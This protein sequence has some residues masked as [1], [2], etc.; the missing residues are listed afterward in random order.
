M[1]SAIRPAKH[2]HTPTNWNIE[3]TTSSTSYNITS[4]RHSNAANSFNAFRLPETPVVRKAVRPLPPSPLPHQPAAQ[5]SPK[6]ISFH[7]LP[8]SP[9]R[10][11][12]YIPTQG[13]NPNFIGGVRSAFDTP[14][15][16]SLRRPRTAPSAMPFRPSTALSSKLPH[17][18]NTSHGR[19]RSQRHA[20]DPKSLD[21]LSPVKTNFQPT[22]SRSM[23][24]P[25]PIQEHVPSLVTKADASRAGVERVRETEP[26]IRE[27]L[28][29]FSV[30][31]TV[32]SF[33][34]LRE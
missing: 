32:V 9:A 18:D 1:S 4:P 23:S 5:I 13:L 12:S 7:A 14:T 3:G 27:Q 28:A 25:S 10:S 21:T 2:Y 24:Y 17:I 11:S 26:S 34:F 15:K 20:R 8:K 6:S 29:F 19:D 22:H 30:V 33:F 16:P 31:T